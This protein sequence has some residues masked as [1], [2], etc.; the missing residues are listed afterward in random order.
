MTKRLSEALKEL[1][2]SDAQSLAAEL[3]LSECSDFSKI[4][5][6]IGVEAS[7]VL[8]ASFSGRTLAIPSAESLNECLQVAGA[9]VELMSKS[10]TYVRNSYPEKAVEKAV[11]LRDK[12]KLIMENREEVVSLLH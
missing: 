9:A 3:A 12:L 6:V 1:K 8:V 5:R 2:R 4:V 7:L 11:V 10:T